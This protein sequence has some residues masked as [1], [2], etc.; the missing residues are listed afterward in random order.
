MKK[1]FGVS[2]ICLSFMLGALAYAA[3][4]V[5]QI[6]NALVCAICSQR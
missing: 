6:V 3:D 2:M 1:V 5:L 4:A